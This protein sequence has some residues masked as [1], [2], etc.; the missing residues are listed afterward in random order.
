MENP[1]LSKNQS[2]RLPSIKLASGHTHS[3]HDRHPFVTF[4]PFFL[5]FQKLAKGVETGNVDAWI[6]N[7]ALPRHSGNKKAWL[8]ITGKILCHQRVRVRMYIYIY[9]ILGRRTSFLIT[10]TNRADV[11]G[12]RSNKVS[13]NID[14]VLSLSLSFSR[15]IIIKVPTSVAAFERTTLPSA[16]LPTSR[17]VNRP[18]TTRF[19]PPTMDK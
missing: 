9:P 10:A 7:N 17:R 13:W 6:Q 2:L 14:P 5:P 8:S 15:R 16:L 18:R 19:K 3:R 4:V 12:G 1:S 11:G